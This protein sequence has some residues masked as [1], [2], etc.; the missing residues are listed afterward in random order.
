MRATRPQT[1][2]LRPAVLLLLLLI[3]LPLRSQGAARSGGVTRYLPLTRQSDGPLTVDPQDRAAAVALYLDL[4]LSSEGI[5]PAWNGSHASC[6][7]GSTSEAF[8]AAVARRINYF[9][10][11]A[12]VPAEVTLS[13]DSSL[14][15]QRAALMMSANRR[16]SH[17]PTPDW[18][19]Y[20]PQGA[21]AAG[22]S[23]LFL[24]I[25]GP[26]AITGYMQDPGGGNHAVGHRRWILYPHTQR[27][28]T[29]DLP[30]R[31]GYPASNALWV[32]DGT[33]P[34][35]RPPTREPYVA[36]PPP[37]YVPDDLVFSRWSFSYPAADFSAAVVTMSDATGSIPLTVQ[38]VVNGFGE[39]TL[40]WE[41]QRALVS[42]RP[43]TVTLQQIF[44][45]GT[46]HTFSYQVT[47]IDP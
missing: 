14:G 4:Y 15:A 27:M 18:L 44:L 3:L 45:A 26:A 29:G 9:R 20:A 19:C 28:G 5:D 40:V 12:G 11:M 23:N 17:S 35:T 21:E 22:R 32:I 47:P 39:N 16:L 31:D 33:T 2:R 46:P 36:W 34:P 24:G 25:M 8:Q 42:E 7:P 43:V 1:S 37:G 41:P 6:D 13:P 10:A 30:A 38:P